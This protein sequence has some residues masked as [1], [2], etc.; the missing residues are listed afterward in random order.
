MG[1]ASVSLIAADPA[2]LDP[3]AVDQLHATARLE[4]IE[5]VVGLP[6]LHAGN[7]IAVGAAF[8][9]SGHVYPHLV[10][11]DIGCG[12]AVWETGC[13]LRQ[14]RLGAAERKLHGLDTPWSGDIDGALA[15]AGLPPDMADPSLGTIGGGNHFVE[16]QRVEEVVDPSCFDALELDRDRLWMMVH[17]GSRGLGHAILQ[18]HVAASGSGEM[19]ADG[20]EGQAYLRQHDRALAWAVLNRRIIAERFAEKLGFDGRCTL[21]ICHNSVTPHQG[22]W[23]FAHARRKS[24]RMTSAPS[25]S[26]ER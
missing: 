2:R 25:R 15:A 14:F 17:S 26:R 6:D 19:A 9:S 1:Q 18:S 3:V 7:G 10:G 23:L 12:M 24:G 5:R 22:G 4:G 8:W 16:L 13:S 21:D 11:S 20:P